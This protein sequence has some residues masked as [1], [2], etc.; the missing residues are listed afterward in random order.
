MSL[1]Y[2]RLPVVC[3]Q[4]L[5]GSFNEQSAC[6]VFTKKS[7]SRVKAKSQSS[8]TVIVRNANETNKREIMNVRR[9]SDDRRDPIYPKSLA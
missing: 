7:I 4:P 2:G 3:A 5:E 8:L 6:M 9:P 1:G